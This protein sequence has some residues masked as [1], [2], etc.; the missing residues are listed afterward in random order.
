MLSN[1]AA[2]ETPP[3][4]INNLT[5]EQT[6]NYM[7]KQFDPKRFVVRERFR[8]WNEMERRPGESIQELATRIRHAAATCDFSNLFFQNILLILFK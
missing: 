3:K 5:M 7:K 8:F 4:N 6:K 1:L 2:Q